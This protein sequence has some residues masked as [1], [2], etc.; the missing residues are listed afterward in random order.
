MVQRPPV[1]DPKNYLYGIFQDNTS[2]ASGYIEMTDDYGD[3]GLVPIN[4]VEVYIYIFLQ[5]VDK[6]KNNM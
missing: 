3:T 1:V 6:R 4:Y 2:T 5:H